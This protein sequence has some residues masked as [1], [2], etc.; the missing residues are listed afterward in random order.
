MKDKIN[1][2][3]DQ[4][5]LDQET[6]E[7]LSTLSLDKVKVNEK[8]GS[9]TFVLNSKNIL[10]VDDYH[11]LRILSEQ[12]FKSIKK[13][14]I[15]IQAVNIDNNLLEDYYRYA[16]Q[17]V[18]DILVFS[19]I[20]E[21]SL[22]TLDGSYYIETTNE[23]EERQVRSFLPKLNY[24]LNLYGF[25][26]NIQSYLNEDKENLIKEEITKELEIATTNVITEEKVEPSKPVY[27]PNGEGKIN[28]RRQIG[29]ASCRERV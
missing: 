22:I 15:S 28:Y 2:L 20:F 27:S 16:L 10:A 9:W 29:R 1:I 11:K 26:D 6:K 18:K 3:F 14:I 7:R 25:E 13:V 17:D 5:N 21:D 4:I 23:E 19:S 12:A 24:L 8:T